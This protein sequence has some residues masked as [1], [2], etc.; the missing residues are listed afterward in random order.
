M[1]PGNVRRAVCACSETA[2][3]CSAVSE[4]EKRE[5][6]TPQR[7][8][9][10]ETSVSLNSAY[11]KSRSP[12][13]QLSICKKIELASFCFFYTLS[14]DEKCMLVVSLLF[15]WM[16]SPMPPLPAPWTWRKE[17]SILSAAHSGEQYYIILLWKNFG[18]C[19]ITMVTIDAWETE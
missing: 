5:T 9:S 18:R 17:T 1:D 2:H 7:I 19:A 13:C 12:H 16:S 14:I 4:N 6:L 8:A 10:P 3:R 11:Y 15:Y